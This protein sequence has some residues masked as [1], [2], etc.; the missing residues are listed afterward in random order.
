MQVRVEWGWGRN[1]S[2]A[3]SRG[4]LVFALHP[5]ERKAH[6][7][8]SALAPKPRLTVGARIQV[9]KAAYTQ[10]PPVR[11]KAVDYEISTLD[12]WNYALV[13]QQAAADSSVIFDPTPSP[14]W[15]P[16][17]PFDDSGAYPFSV[18]VKARRV[19]RWGFWSQSNDTDVPP[20]SPIDC[21]DPGEC[22][23]ETEP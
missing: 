11:P 1:D 6:L 7:P 17:F 3:I 4:P 22:G 18:R 16:S 23:E 12:P 20:Q 10:D 19:A 14:D 2:V 8:R 13:L 15:S 21:R 5:R 9:I